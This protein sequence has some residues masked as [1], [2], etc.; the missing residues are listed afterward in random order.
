MVL[1]S[2]DPQDHR[3]GG[4]CWRRRNLLS[5]LAIA[6]VFVGAMV[7]SGTPK[8]FLASI[9]KSP[10]AAP[11]KAVGLDQVSQ[12]LEKDV[13]K[14]VKKDV[15]VDV[16]TAEKDATSIVDR[17]IHKELSKDDANKTK[18][19]AKLKKDIEKNF[20]RKME[21]DI[22]EDVHRDVANNFR[23]S[24]ERQSRGNQKKQEESKSN[25]VTEL[26][27]TPP[28]CCSW[29]MVHCGKT[30]GKCKGGMKECEHCKGSW[31]F[32]PQTVCTQG[33]SVESPLPK[34][35][36][37]AGL[38]T[39]KQFKV[40]ALSYNLFWWKLFDKMKGN[41][42]SAGHL[43]KDTIGDT[44]YDFM[45]FQECNQPY[46]VLWD[47]GLDKEFGVKHTWSNMCIAYRKT[48][49]ELLDDGHEVVAQDASWGGPGQNYGQRMAMWMR[50]RHKDT[51]QTVFFM[52]HHGPLPLSSGGDWG[53]PTTARKLLNVIKRNATD[54]DAVIF[55]GDFN[56]N[57]ESMTIK[58]LNCR[59]LRV[60]SGTAPE[61]GLDHI[62]TNID[63]SQVI[64]KVVLGMGGSDHHAIMATFDFAPP[65]AHRAKHAQK[66]S[67]K[68]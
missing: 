15:K 56:S 40:K 59:L 45:G 28:G 5:G 50:L 21:K 10:H 39:K 29:D 3:P 57:L 46:Q 25:N 53:G 52:N 22:D 33:H 41:G 27:K 16:K 4:H 23:G 12:D 61:P 35:W 55:V 6:L 48:T 20:H 37:F 44:P 43:I 7:T 13:E 24:K 1:H 9:F 30:K 34:I 38:S 47:A 67:A 58:Q 49:W 42:G 26:K 54:G 62:F 11:Q 17:V 64:D 63:E 36:P 8:I 31:I 32:Q 68:V 66:V 14:D 19:E 60:I 18:L 51:E 2:S 65:K